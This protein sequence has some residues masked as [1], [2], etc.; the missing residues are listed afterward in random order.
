MSVNEINPFIETAERIHV[1]RLLEADDC[2]D[3][4]ARAEKVPRWHDAL[5]YKEGEKELVVDASVRKNRVLQERDAANLFAPYRAKFMQ[6]FAKFVDETQENFFIISLL[7]IN[8]YEPGGHFHAHVDALPTHHRY[9]RY[10]VVCYL[11]DDFVDGG[12][13]FPT[14]GRTYRP[15]AGQALLFPSHYLHE[16]SPVTSG[17]KF[18][19]VF[20]LCDAA[21]ITDD[22]YLTEGV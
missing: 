1:V 22:A 4:I 15:S 18:V 2:A 7:V 11:N 3:L 6:R 10:S 16:A 21:Y 19:F 9:R 17:R 13:T 5:S 14:L 20:F 8:C 12:T